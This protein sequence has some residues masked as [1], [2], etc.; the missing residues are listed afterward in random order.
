MSPQF[1]LYHF[2]I[3]EENSRQNCFASS[4]LPS[5]L[6]YVGIKTWRKQT[7]LAHGEDYSLPSGHSHPWQPPKHHALKKFSNIHQ[8]TVQECATWWQG[9]L[10]A[11]AMESI[12]HAPQW[13]E[14]TSNVLWC[15]M[16]IL[17]V[18]QSELQFCELVGGSIFQLKA[19][20]RPWNVCWYP[21]LPKKTSIKKLQVKLLQLQV[22][23]T[24]RTQ[25][26]KH[27]IKM[28]WSKPPQILWRQ[29]LDCRPPHHCPWVQD[30][31]YFHFGGANEDSGTEHESHLS[32]KAC[33]WMNGNLHYGNIAKCE[34]RG[35]V[36]S[37]AK[38]FPPQCLYNFKNLV[39]NSP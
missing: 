36:L 26:P 14:V 6:A 37:H 30:V 20:L 12:E 33:R 2:I 1:Y 21:H 10:W 18:I 25:K 35:A 3:L 13:L 19:C 27:A 23:G 11:H 9:S 17:D 32:R 29:W 28:S 5:L 34:L 38:A 8:K 7:C 22:T 39:Q 24:S 31:A 16:M 15:C 4:M